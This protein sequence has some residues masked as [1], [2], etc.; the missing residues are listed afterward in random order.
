MTDSGDAGYCSNSGLDSSRIVSRYLDF[1]NGVIS[2][3]AIIG[4]ERANW[5]EGHE[6][7]WICADCVMRAE[8]QRLLDI[9]T[10]GRNEKCPCGNG[11][12]YK[13]CHSG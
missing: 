1:K 12:K 4:K 13:K 5:Y 10:E 8:A 3:I 9:A 11:K 7:A 6:S 2:Q